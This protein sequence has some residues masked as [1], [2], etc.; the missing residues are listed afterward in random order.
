[1]N[2]ENFFV[3]KEWL[4]PRNKRCW[5]VC[6]ALLY[7][8]L[9][10][11]LAPWLIKDQLPEMSQ[12]FIKRTAT[13]EKASFNPWTLSLRVEGLNIADSDNSTLAEAESLLVN[14]QL[15]SLFRLA[16]VF[17]EVEL[18]QPSLQLVRYDL[19]NSNISHL[20]DDLSA[21]SGTSTEPNSEPLRLIIDGLK[22]SGGEA[23]LTDLFN[24][25]K[26][27]TTL[28]P[29]NIS[30]A[31]LSTLPNDSG[32]QQVSIQAENGAR[33]SWS[34]NLTISPLRST[35]RLKL[36][37]SP[38]PLLHRYLNAQLAFD[39]QNC[40]LDVELNYSVNMLADDS[41]SASINDLNLSLRELIISAKNDGGEILNLPELSISNGTLQWPEAVARIE[42][43]RLTEPVA[44]LWLNPDGSLNLQQLLN[45]TNNA[46]QIAADTGGSPATAAESATKGTGDSW[47]LSLGRLALDNMQVTFIDHGLE[48]VTP[49]RLSDIN[50]DITNLSNQAGQKSPLQL[51][52]VL[53]SG[54]SLSAKGEI[55]LM[56]ALDLQTQL[57]LSDIALRVAQP[58]IDQAV[59]AS[60]EDGV[61]NISALVQSSTDEMLAAQ[62][63][64]GIAGLKIRDTTINEPLVGWSALEIQQ[65]EFAM[66]ASTLDISR[67][68]LNE[69]FARLKINSQGATNFQSLL[70]PGESTNSEASAEQSTIAATDKQPGSAS[71]LRV[72]IGETSISGG[73]VDF[74]DL[75]L[76]LPFSALISEFGGKI[77]AF[78]SSSQQPSTLDFEGKVG[79]YGLSTIKGDINLLDPTAKADVTALFRNI[80][81]PDLTPYTVQFVGQKIK[82]GKLDLDLSYRLEDRLVRGD[83]KVLLTQF[84]L[85]EKHEH[86]EAMDLPLGMAIGLLRDVNGAINM[87]LAVKGD[88]DDP[89]FSASGII[90]KAFANLIVKAVAAPFKL[91]GALIPG[92]D[93]DNS[94]I[95]AF[96]AG[97]SRLTPPEQ[98]KLSLIAQALQQRPALVLN[99]YTGYEPNTDVAGLQTLSAEAL[100]IQELGDTESSAEQ[101][102]KRQQ[103]ALEKLLRRNNALGDTSLQELRQRFTGVDNGQLDNVAYITEMKLL[104]ANAQTVDEIQLRN[105]A[106][107]RLAAML[108]EL[109]KNGLDEG[110]LQTPESGG[111][112][113]TSD[114]QVTIE[115]GL[116]TG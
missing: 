59:A 100:L 13:I 84:E 45:P 41:I 97:E 60:L 61:L 33:L 71:P 29:I 73:S 110:R 90:L 48:T 96:A 80:S 30:L 7:S 21:S 55:S 39:S 108:A 103:K 69:P 34:G 70:K 101:L 72:R 82:A 49:V 31:N 47:E 65:L 89:S 51:G 36:S 4:N 102:I 58:W 107:A 74:T 92:L 16:L 113:K 11:L 87:N 27:S 19:E 77:S 112:I 94:N 37:G 104:L 76:P 32:E 12:N 14:L 8:L 75:A 62:A 111:K 46:E 54:G 99:V 52:A 81:M 35:G 2:V 63:D 3:W 64:I 78:D 40:C 115:L 88:L 6:A 22:I 98:E 53:E 56:P 25:E 20:I 50:L 83:N 67:I 109:Q 91:L 116:E 79:D 66:D 44:G 10:F 24:S 26:F 114:K 86:P 43:L 93:E 68:K 95:I 38:L 18:V 106:T 5:L 57:E 15:R 105:L 85:G 42:E 28:G 23:Q 17:G 1:M 9:G